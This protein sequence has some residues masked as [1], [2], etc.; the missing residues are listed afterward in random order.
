MALP[1]PATSNNTTNMPSVLA[2]GFEII[3]GFIGK[4]F[5][6]FYS[7][8]SRSSA[9]MNNQGGAGLSPQCN[10]E[11]E[12]RGNPGAERS[13]HPKPKIQK[14]PNLNKVLPPALSA[15]LEI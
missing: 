6:Y 11:T 14:A 3:C 2:K 8:H 5:S 12:S 1:A 4:K 9:E 13:G 7:T 10:C 15:A